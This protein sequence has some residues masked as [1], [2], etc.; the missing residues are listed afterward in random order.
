MG[1]SEPQNL[2]HRSAGGLGAFRGGP[3]GTRHDS[4]L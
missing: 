1:S 2:E 4:E 3:K